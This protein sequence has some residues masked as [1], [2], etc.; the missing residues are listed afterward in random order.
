MKK[1]KRIE[2]IVHVAQT[3]E[4]SAVRQLKEWRRRLDE[5]KQR[6]SELQ[7]YHDEYSKQFHE[8][9]NQGTSATRVRDFRVFL[10]RLDE[11]ITQQRE[12]V[13]I[14][15]EELTRCVHRWHEIRNKSMSLGKIRHRY[16]TEERRWRNKRD[17][18][19][20]DDQIAV[21]RAHRHRYQE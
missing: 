10:N 17:Q 12:T 16:E 19:E 6:L 9:L 7:N 14:T 11:G 2:P 3:R 13:K 8:A 20:S 5:Q 21:H 1:S 18:N 15:Q 4:Q